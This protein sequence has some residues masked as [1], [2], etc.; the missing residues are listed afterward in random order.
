MRVVLTGRWAR[1]R[2]TKSP[3]SS[4]LAANSLANKLPKTHFPGDTGKGGRSNDRMSYY[5]ACGIWGQVT[6]SR[7]VST[8]GYTVSAS[9][10]SKL[11][12]NAV[13]SCPHLLINQSTIHKKDVV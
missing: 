7:L 8:S 2:R 1:G 13:V 9:T 5:D 10:V 4:R 6:A 11:W 12:L 3:V